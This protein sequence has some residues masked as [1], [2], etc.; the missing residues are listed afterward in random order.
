MKKF[1]QPWHI[2]LTFVLMSVLVGPGLALAAPQKTKLALTLKIDPTSVNEGQTATGTV[3]HNGSTTSD[4]TVTLQ[5]SNSS[6]VTVPASV[7]IPKGSNS[8][9]FSINALSDENIEGNQ[10]YTITATATNYR[11]SSASLTVVDVSTSAP[12]AN[13]P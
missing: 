13:T 3:S 7:I 10:T 2:A 6:E 9:T 11:S 4:L 5:S 12:T 8:R 1:T